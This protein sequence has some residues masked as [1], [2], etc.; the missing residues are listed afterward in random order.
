MSEN[1]AIWWRHH[2]PHKSQ[3]L[4]KVCPCHSVTMPDFPCYIIPSS[5]HSFTP[6]NYLVSIF[7]WS[8]RQSS[9]LHWCNL[10]P[11]SIGMKTRNSIS[12]WRHQMET[13]SALLAIC[14][15]NSPHKGQ[16]SGAL[17]F[18]LI[19]VRIN[20][21]VNNGEAGDLIRHRAHYD[22]IVMCANRLWTH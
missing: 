6:W 3:W 21:W 18:S 19:C 2:V 1:V 10:A 16:W 13:F 12:W 4:W 5:M 22:V 11:L 20:D 17:M 15:G 8:D 14:A 9:T 7:N